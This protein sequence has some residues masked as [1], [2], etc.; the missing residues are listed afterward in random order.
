MGVALDPLRANPVTALRPGAIRRLA[1]DFANNTQNPVTTTEA[2]LEAAE[3]AGCAF[4]ALRVTD[5]LD[6][7]MKSRARWRAASPLGA[8]DGIPISWKDLFDVAG[9][10]TTAGSRAFASAPPSARDSVL[11]QRASRGGLINIG[12]T[13]LSE[14]AFSGLGMNAV[15]GTPDG[16]GG[17]GDLLPG[18]SSSGSAA[19]VATGAG[20]AGIGTDTAGSVR[21]P[22]AFWGLVGFRPSI[23]RYPIQGMF[24]LART[25]DT[26]GL[27]AGSVDDC[28]CIDHVLAPEPAVPLQVD[29]QNQLFVVE[30]NMLDRQ[31]ADP[32]VTERFQDWVK[33]VER[34][35][36][37]VQERSLDVVLSTID[38]IDH[39]GWLG[40]IEA[41]EL[42]ARLLSDKSRSDPLEATTRARLEK[43]AS[44]SSSVQVSLRLLQTNLMRRARAE[45]GDAILV[46]PTV[47]FTA[48]PKAQA[49][50]SAAAFAE[51]NLAT[52]RTTMILS[53]LLMPAISLPLPSGNE[54]LPAGV[55]LSA[56]PGDDR[57]LLEVA[58]AVEDVAG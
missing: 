54:Q 6:E 31:D 32:S 53:F 18:G 23:G 55:L 51:L 49:E 21:V 11:V 28:I 1:A 57:R 9:M 14:L 8:L 30:R 13:N 47:P 4:I 44:L 7:A 10:T 15:F 35:G 2:A 52:L 16:P 39:Q 37:T 45:L 25:F 20:L 38:A 5:A 41:A 3:R 33:H 12:K 22:A 48:P 50:Q 36:A 24:P 34:S 27:I 29:L 46:C 19:A 58:A 40:S 42:H 43:S 17:R 56:L 26:P